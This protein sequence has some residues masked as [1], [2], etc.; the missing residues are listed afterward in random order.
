MVGMFYVNP[1]ALIF[2]LTLVKLVQ[3]SDTVVVA[4]KTVF[5]QSEVSDPSWSGPT[6]VPAL[7][8][9]SVIITFWLVTQNLNIHCTCW[10]HAN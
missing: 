6:F 2:K 7:H 4:Y 10:W 1:L 3:T 5:A 9:Y 8:V